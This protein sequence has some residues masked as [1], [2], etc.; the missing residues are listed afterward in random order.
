MA[1][2]C[3]DCGRPA[4]YHAAWKTPTMSVPT[5]AYACEDHHFEGMILTANYQQGAQ[6]HLEPVQAP[7]GPPH[8]EGLADYRFRGDRAKDAAIFAHVA[9]VHP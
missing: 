4:T 9:V 2:Q 5:F 1:P 7:Q 8:G 6:R 3:D